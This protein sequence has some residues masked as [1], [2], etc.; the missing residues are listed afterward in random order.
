M[1]HGSQLGFTDERVPGIPDYK[2]I[3]S[4][5]LAPG[6]RGRQFSATGDY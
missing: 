6:V 5:S 1:D 4:L 2:D 3:L